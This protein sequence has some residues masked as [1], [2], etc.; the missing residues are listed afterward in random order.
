MAG[1]AITFK[2]EGGREL[3][4]AFAQLGSQSTMKRTAQR[5]EKVALEPMRA[6]AERLAP[7]LTGDTAERIE[8][9]NA[10]RRSRSKDKDVVETF[11]GINYKGKKDQATVAA[12]LEFGNDR[13]GAE[14]FL[15]PAYETKKSDVVAKL[16]EA[17]WA[18][19]GVSAARLAKR[20][21]KG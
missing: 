11:I 20:R 8:I 6:E 19:I 5:G 16:G 14:P 13:Q 3:E 2:F 4:L 7:K 18:E 1:S 9:G 15:R 17:L 12:I 10:D 21:A